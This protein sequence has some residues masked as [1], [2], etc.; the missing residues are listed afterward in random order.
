MIPMR[1]TESPQERAHRM[2]CH[3]LEWK[4][5]KSSERE[6]NVALGLSLSLWGRRIA[7]FSIP[8]W[9]VG[10]PGFKSQRPHHNTQRP[11]SQILLLAFPEEFDLVKVA[12]VFESS[13]NEFLGLLGLFWRWLSGIRH[14]QNLWAECITGCFACFCGQ[15]FSSR[16]G[17]LSFWRILLWLSSVGRCGS[18]FFW[19]VG[20]AV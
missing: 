9:G 17:Y 4:A 2:V 20:F 16:G 11:Y 18:L 3:C 5:I 7:W 12:N 10:N 15:A 14:F 19:F 13:F 6:N 8:A 1:R